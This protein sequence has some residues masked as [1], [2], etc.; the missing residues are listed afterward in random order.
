M[1]LYKLCVYQRT[2]VPGA[3]LIG[4]DDYIPVARGDRKLLFNKFSALCKYEMPTLRLTC[5]LRAECGDEDTIR[6]RQE[7]IWEFFLYVGG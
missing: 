1:G 6:I 5:I 3:R 4:V 7:W 2:V